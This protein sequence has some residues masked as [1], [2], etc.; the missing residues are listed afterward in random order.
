MLPQRKHG[1]SSK[2]AQ[3]HHLVNPPELVNVVI[4]AVCS[5]GRSGVVKHRC[6]TSDPI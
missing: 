2:P 4:V 1:L 5:I 3:N 6:P